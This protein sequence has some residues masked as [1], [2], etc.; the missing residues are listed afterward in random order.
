MVCP[1]ILNPQSFLL[2]QVIN[3]H[4]SRIESSLQKYHLLVVIAHLK[5]EKATDFDH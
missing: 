4:K 2:K 3:E 1:I 5:G